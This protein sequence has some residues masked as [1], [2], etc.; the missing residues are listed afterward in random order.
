M[1]KLRRSN[2]AGNAIEVGRPDGSD[3]V[4]SQCSNFELYCLRYCYWKP[5]EDVAKNR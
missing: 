5:M 4:K 2:R 3:A 1:K